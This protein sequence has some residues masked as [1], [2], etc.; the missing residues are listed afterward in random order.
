MECNDRKE[1]TIK[2]IMLDKLKDADLVL[3]GIGEEFG[4]SSSAMEKDALFTG[5]LEQIENNECLSGMTSAARKIYL[6]HCEHGRIMQA[7]DIL[8]DLLEDKNYFIIS[9]CTDDYIYETNLKKEQIVTPC[10]GYRLLQCEAAC[11]KELYP[12]DTQLL[13]RMEEV[14]LGRAGLKKTDAE[15]VEIP[16]CPKCGKRLVFNNIEAENYVE[17]GYLGQWN[18]YR[19]WLQGTVNKKLCVL[20]LGVGMKYPSVIRWPFEKIVFFNQKS[21]LFRVHSK[22]FQLSEEIRERG[23]KIEEKPIDFLINR[24]V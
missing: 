2:E 17:E 18:E 13:K 14:L 4:I 8:A 3:V 11:D 24:F 22:L 20:E 1:E 21:H 16:L 9:T 23:F 7:Y 6:Q 12:A 19:K 5:Y 15:K 10:G